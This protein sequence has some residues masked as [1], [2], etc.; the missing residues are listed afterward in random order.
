V[1]HEQADAAQS[2]RPAM[3]L[4]DGKRDR[5]LPRCRSWCAR[6][7]GGASATSV[8]GQAHGLAPCRV[9]RRLRALLLVRPLGCPRRQPHR[10]MFPGDAGRK[11]RWVAR[12]LH[13]YGS[14][15]PTSRERGDG[16]SSSGLHHSGPPP[17]D[18][19]PALAEPAS[20]PLSREEL[21]R[22]LASGRGRPGPDQLRRLPRRAGHQQPVP[23]PAAIRPR[24]AVDLP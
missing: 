20:A 8:P 1:S 23:G 10:T 4:R 11:R 13:A 19:R 9:R 17:A 15:Q 16:F 22:L 2:I 24:A 12:A 3:A 5:R 7:R 14:H 6:G 18:N 21:P